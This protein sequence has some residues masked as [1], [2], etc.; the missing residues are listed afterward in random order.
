MSKTTEATIALLKGNNASNERKYIEAEGFYTKAIALYREAIDYENQD[1]QKVIKENLDRAYLNLASVLVSNKKCA[2][3]I[4]LYNTMVIDNL[5]LESSKT[6][7]SLNKIVSVA[8]YNLALE[9]ISSS[10]FNKAIE[11]LA[12]AIKSLAMVTNEPDQQMQKTLLYT[13]CKLIEHLENQEN[14][15]IHE[16]LQNALSQFNN[17]SSEDQGLYQEY[18]LHMYSHMGKFLLKNKSADEIKLLIDNAG[19]LAKEVQLTLKDFALYEYNTDK[20]E[21]TKMLVSLFNIGDQL[22]RD[23]LAQIC[24]NAGNAELYDKVLVSVAGEL[25]IDDFNFSDIE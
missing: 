5:L 15:D 24:I 7:V 12:G 17:L 1:D 22:A 25:K 9:Q 3:V 6:M 11:S 23:D 20:K 18:G 2:D 13:H 21:G 8:Y 16:A 4:K 14:Q 10:E 19:S